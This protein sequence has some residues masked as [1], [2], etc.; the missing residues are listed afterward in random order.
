MRP[1]FRHHPP[2]GKSHDRPDDASSWNNEGQTD[3]LDLT[4][5]YSPMSEVLVLPV[6]QPIATDLTAAGNGTVLYGQSAGGLT[7]NISYDSSVTAL[8]TSNPL[9]YTEYTAA[10]QQAVNFYQSAIKTPMSVNISFGWGEVGGNTISGGS[11]GQSSTYYSVYSYQ[12]FYNAV[13]GVLDSPTASAVQ[14]AA[15]TTLSPTDPTGGLGRFYISTSQQKALGLGS[16]TG[17]DGF[18]GLNST[19][20]YGWTQPNTAFNGYDAVGAIEHEI[21]EVLGRYDL[22]GASTSPTEQNYTLLDFFHY[23]AAGGAS[24]AAF[25]SAAGVLNEPFVAGYNA[26]LQSYFSYNGTTIT[27]PYD[28]PSQVASGNDVADWTNSVLNDSYGFAFTGATEVVS[29][30]DLQELNVL[31]YEVACFLPGTQIATPLGE[32]PVERLKAGDEILTLHGAARAISWIGKGQ[33]LATR[34]QRNGVTPVIV[35]KGALAD[36]IPNRELRITKG[37]S[38]YIDDVLIPVEYLV[39]HRSILWDD[40]AQQVIFYHIELETHDVLLANGTPA[41][42]YRDDDNRWMFGNARSGRDQADKPPFA[43][44]LTGG[45]VVDRVWQRLLLRS[46]PRPGVPLTTEPDLHLWVDGRRVDGKPQPNGAHLFRLRET[47]AEIRIVSRAGA[48][49][50]LGLARDCR[51]LGVAVRRIILWQGRL[52][53]IAAAADTCLVNGFHEYEADNDFRWT[54]G[55]AVIPPALFNRFS[56]P[57]DVELFVAATTNYP[58]FGDQSL[59]AA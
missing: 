42:T 33:A 24:N 27:L 53:T 4:T 59:S 45:P 36:N 55:D 28:T 18:V 16:Y 54:D 40:H 8:M 39:N 17:T 47:P 37:H 20:A 34:G 15:F 25:G 44:V 43:T 50:E 19:V 7:I 26:S 56:G 38:L 14:K 31:G 58:F 5:A 9:L 48:P 41:E 21:S 10:V 1:V 49:D 35:T 30:T 52:P 57:F 22:L 2:A 32:V 23:A 6:S 11:I 46:G 51:M 3:P 13:A 29:P 12:T